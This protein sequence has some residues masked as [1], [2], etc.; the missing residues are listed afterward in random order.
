MSKDETS[1]TSLVIEWRVVNN[2]NNYTRKTACMHGSLGGRR[3][4]Q[5]HSNSGLSRF[6]IIVKPMKDLI[7]AQ[8]STNTITSFMFNTVFTDYCVATDVNNWICDISSTQASFCDTDN[9]SV[10]VFNYNFEVFILFT[11]NLVFERN[12]EQGLF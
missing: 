8:T 11:R 4:D 12:R 2:G 3:Y 10:I 9:I 1:K 6:S 7:K 5:R